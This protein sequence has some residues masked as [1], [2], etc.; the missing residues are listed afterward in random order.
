VF[1]SSQ[2][3]GEGRSVCNASRNRSNRFAVLQHIRELEEQLDV[4]GP[5]HFLPGDRSVRLPRVVE[6][7]SA[8]SIE[9]ERFVRA[10]KLLQDLFACWRH[11]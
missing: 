6:N 9:R 7:P 10:W 11:T 1:G 4:R 5:R 2:G 8:E 3:Q